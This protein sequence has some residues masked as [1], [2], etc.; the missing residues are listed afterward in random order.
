MGFW[1]LATNQRGNSN[2]AIG[3]L[4]D[5]TVDGL[6]NATAIGANA[7]VSASNSLVLGNNANVG[8]GTSAPGAKLDVEGNIKITD[9]TQA[10]GYVLTSDA[11]G[12]ASWQTLPPSGWGLSGNAGTTAGTNFIGTT[13]ANAMDVR[14]NNVIKVRFTTQGAIETYNTGQSVFIGQGAGAN[15]NLANNANVFVG[16]QSGNANISGGNNTATGYQS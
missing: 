16:Y 5:V 2:T 7:Q 9:G 3:A 12:L 4:A 6:T 15:D 10:S 8:I 14:T 1:A 11:N 13:D